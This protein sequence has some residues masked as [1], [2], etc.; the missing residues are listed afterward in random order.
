MNQHVKLVFPPK[1]S[2]VQDVSGIYTDL[3]LQYLLIEKIFSHAVFCKILKQYGV[4]RHIQTFLKKFK[5][6]NFCELKRLKN[7]SKINIF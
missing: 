6:L 1:Q 7:G 2:V 4:V 5:K 3:K